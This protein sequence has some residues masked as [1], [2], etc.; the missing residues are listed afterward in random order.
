MS[1]QVGDSV[2]LLPNDRLLYMPYIGAVV[3]CTGFIS[4]DPNRP[5]FGDAPWFNGGWCDPKLF[6]L[7]DRPPGPYEDMFA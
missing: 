3:T 6:E 2:R 7:V 4:N 1:F 5:T